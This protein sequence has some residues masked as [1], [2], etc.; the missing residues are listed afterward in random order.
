MQVLRALIG[1]SNCTVTEPFCDAR[2]H[3]ARFNVDSETTGKILPLDIEK[4]DL[5]PSI[6]QA[7][8]WAEPRGMEASPEPPCRPVPTW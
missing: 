2:H 1:T 5:D 8:A 6:A 3:C 4:Q 7:L